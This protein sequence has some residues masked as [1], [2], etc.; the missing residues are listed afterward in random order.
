MPSVFLYSQVNK[1]GHEKKQLKQA[2][3]QCS[4]P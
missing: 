4:F 3:V 1:K 2:C